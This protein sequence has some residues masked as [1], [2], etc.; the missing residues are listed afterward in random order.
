MPVVRNGPGTRAAGGNCSRQ[1]KI[2]LHGYLRGTRHYP[3]LSTAVPAVPAVL[4][5]KH[6]S[7]S[8]TVVVSPIGSLASAQPTMIMQP[9]HMTGN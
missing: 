9:L 6:K 8:P 3:V 4:L 2:M 1:A 5:G 7:M